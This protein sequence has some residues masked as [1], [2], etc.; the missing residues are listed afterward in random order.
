MT[1]DWPDT[2]SPAPRRYRLRLH[3][4]EHM[5]VGA[6]GAAANAHRRGRHVRGAAQNY[7][8]PGCLGRERLNGP[9][10][11]VVERL[12][13]TVYGDYSRFRPGSGVVAHADRNRGSAY[14]N[15]KW[16]TS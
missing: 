8:L 11:S 4:R 15:P 5:I 9:E 14:V 13:R 10:R 3:V 12:L 6:M 16:S 2:P 1:F 7:S